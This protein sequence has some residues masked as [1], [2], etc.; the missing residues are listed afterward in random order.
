MNGKTR[1][2]CWNA[3]IVYEAQRDHVSDM[4]DTFNRMDGTRCSIK[5]KIILHDYN[6]VFK[7]LK[8]DALYL[9]DFIFLFIISNHHAHNTPSARGNR[10]LNAVWAKN[11]SSS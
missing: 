4:F 9:N 6:M 3:G 1:E 5:C 11:I 8:G 7:C 10:P 2:S